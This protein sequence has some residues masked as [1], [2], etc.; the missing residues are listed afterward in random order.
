MPR[1]KEEDK[2][3]SELLGGV[4]AMHDPR[5]KTNSK[6]ELKRVKPDGPL[7]AEKRELFCQMQLQGHSKAESYIKAGYKPKDKK[8]ASIDADQLFHCADVQA[9]LYELRMHNGAHDEAAAARDDATI[10]QE[11][12]VTQMKLLLVAAK[13]DNSL[14]LAREIIKDMGKEIGMFQETNNPNDPNIKTLNSPNH[15]GQPINI[16][17]LVAVVDDAAAGNRDSTKSTTTIDGEINKDP[18]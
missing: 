13:N 9:R 5:Y 6:G 11:F 2:K 17:A 1:K 10:S 4:D 8:R 3:P 16:S 12:V 15:P 14:K 7:K 18:D